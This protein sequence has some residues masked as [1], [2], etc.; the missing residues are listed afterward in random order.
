MHQHTSETTGTMPPGSHLI[1]DRGLVKQP[2]APGSEKY[3]NVPSHVKVTNIERGGRHNR[4]MVKQMAEHLA[5][6]QKLA[7]TMGDA[8]KRV[9]TE[10][11]PSMS[12]H[13]YSTFVEI[14]DPSPR[15]V[16]LP[17]IPSAEASP[18]VFS[19]GASAM[20]APA[21][22]LSHFQ[23]E[24]PRPKR[25][26]QNARTLKPSPRYA[27]GRTLVDARADAD[28]WSLPFGPGDP[29][30]GRADEPPGPHPYDVLAAMPPR[31]GGGVPPPEPVLSAGFPSEI[32]PGGGGGV[33]G[34]VGG[35]NESFPTDGL[36]EENPAILAPALVLRTQPI[37]LLV[38]RRE[39]A[40][41]GLRGLLHSL[42]RVRHSSHRLP[43]YVARAYQGRLQ[44]AIGWY[45][46]TTTE[47]V[48][49]LA[50]EVSLPPYCHWWPSASLLTAIGGPQPPSPLSPSLV[51]PPTLPR[52]TSV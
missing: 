48:E 22:L 52:A 14:G 34:G 33:V 28:P 19:K 50:F 51:H 31:A 10:Q 44:H 40:L 24:K 38:Q 26:G 43:D 42:S 46:V 9:L 8:E 11:Y 37:P 18:R 12:E 3:A 15:G 32:Y 45:R 39:Q 21:D 41:D 20:L 29:L 5:Q 23:P 16:R 4:V 17:Q 7:A 47:L 35:S 25:G 13:L 49:R 27:G 30:L 2:P 6:I 1:Y 36:W